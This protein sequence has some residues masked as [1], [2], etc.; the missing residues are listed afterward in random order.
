MSKGLGALI[1]HSSRY[2]NCNI[3]HPF[4][5]NNLKQNG[6]NDPPNGTAQYK[7]EDNDYMR[8]YTQ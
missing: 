1:D 8:C 4:H 3:R 6:M 7:I 5:H 2:G